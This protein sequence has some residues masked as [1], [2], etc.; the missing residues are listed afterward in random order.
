MSKKAKAAPRSR[1]PLPNPK[2]PATEP[3]DVTEQKARNLPMF[4]PGIVINVPLHLLPAYFK[5]YS[6][7]PKGMAAS[8]VL[9]VKREVPEKH[10]E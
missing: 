10:H 1:L 8:G 7:T 5:L 2:L 3:M 9:H 6:L 4:G